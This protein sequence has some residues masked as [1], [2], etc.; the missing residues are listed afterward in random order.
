MKNATSKDFTLIAGPCSV[1]SLNFV[2]QHFKALPEATFLRGGLFKLRT[3]KN[4]FQ[5]LGQKGVELIVRQKRDQDFCFVSEVI[6]ERSLED[7][8]AITD[9]LQIGTRNMYNYPL[10]KKVG[11]TG[12]TVLLKRAMSATISEWLESAQYLNLPDEK[13]IL[14]ERGI[15]SFEPSY[16]NML[17]LNAVAYL[18]QKTPYRV[19]VDPSHAV[20][21]ADLIPQLA[22]ASLA[23]GADGLLIEC[24]PRPKDAL[25]DKEQ[26]LDLFQ[27]R[28]LIED[29][30]ALTPHFDRELRY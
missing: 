10:L 28:N 21:I 23:V 29:L 8:V 25:S 5:G 16:R 26:A 22:K 20:G 4:S 7:L 1:E 2:Q 12:K 11:A 3:K 27:M 30:K 17:D 15:R 14:C 24:H 18:K 6:D 19:F 13:I 9:I